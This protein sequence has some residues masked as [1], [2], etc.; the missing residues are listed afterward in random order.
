MEQK[1]SRRL[2]LQKIGVLAGVVS[3]PSVAAEREIGDLF[4]QTGW[5]VYQDFYGLDNRRGDHNGSA[6]RITP[7]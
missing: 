4:N 7:P 1:K 2:F 3:I 6:T 5:T